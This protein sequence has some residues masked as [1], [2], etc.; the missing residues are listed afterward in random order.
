MSPR[1]KD[2]LTLGIALGIVAL[3]GLLVLFLDMLFPAPDIALPSATVALTVP[4]TD[5]DAP[6]TM[7]EFSDFGCPFC[8]N[9]AQTVRQ[10][11]DLYGQSL[12]V[13]FRHFPTHTNSQ[14]A[15]EAS[16]CSRD[17]GMFWE[18]HDL[19]FKTGDLGMESLKK[20]A[21]QLGLDMA[22]FLRCLES[23]EKNQVVIADYQEAL[24]LQIRGTPTFFINDKVLEGSQPLDSFK[25]VI[26]NELG[27][28]A[29]S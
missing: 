9:A 15:A 2:A 12:Y 8:G 7:V 6:V 3:I 13:E 21:E 28:A 25:R 18:Y 10:L 27:Q 1:R 20:H 19:L 5:S 11:K 22:L 24:R 26:D 29:S 17:Q 23:G 4:E 16:E 14:K